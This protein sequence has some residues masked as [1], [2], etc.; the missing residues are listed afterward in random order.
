MKL[1]IQCGPLTPS[2]SPEGE[3]VPSRW[4]WVRFWGAIRKSFGEI[5][6]LTLFPLADPDI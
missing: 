6:T 5:L 1:E 2:L 4:I 3:R